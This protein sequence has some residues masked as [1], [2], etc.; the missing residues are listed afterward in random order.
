MQGFYFILFALRITWVWCGPFSLLQAVMIPCVIFT[1]RKWRHVAKLKS[2]SEQRYMIWATSVMESSMCKQQVWVQYTKSHQT[3]LIL[4]HC[5]LA[6]RFLC[7]I[8]G[9]VWKPCGT[10]D[11]CCYMALRVPGGLADFWTTNSSSWTWTHRK[12]DTFREK[13]TF[14][15]GKFRDPQAHRTPNRGTHA[16]PIQTKGF[17]NGSGMGGKVKPP[18][19][20]RVAGSTTTKHGIRRT[21][22]RTLHEKDLFS[23]VVSGSLNRWDRWNI[24]SQLAVYIPLIY[25]QIGWLY[26][27]DPT[28]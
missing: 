3:C 8:C 12:G 20:C 9:W 7:N 16:I 22:P 15:A 2:N 21:W 26:A 23:I 4:H 1:K 6:A 10:W 28:D 19:A 17:E 13:L 5:S 14:L 24:I 18:P 27:T 25:C 11:N